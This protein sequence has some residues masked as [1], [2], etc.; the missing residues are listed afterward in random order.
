MENSTSIRPRTFTQP[1]VM[2]IALST[3]A[4]V[5][6]FILYSFIV[7]PVNFASSHDVVS[8]TINLALAV[9]VTLFASIIGIGYGIYR[10]SLLAVN[11]VHALSINNHERLGTFLIIANILSRKKFRRIFYLTSISYAIFF[12]MV[13]Q[14][15]IFR[16]DISF[17]QLYAVSIPSVN[18][19]TCCNFP[20]FVP[21]LSVYL[22]DNLIIVII[23]INLLV[24]VLLSVLVGINITLT[25]CMFQ[26]RRRTPKGNRLSCFTGIGGAT[27]GLF[28]AC[29]ICA[30]TLF[31][32]LLGLVTGMSSASAVTLSVLTP[33]QA[34]FI[35]VSIPTLLY[36]SYVTMKNIRKEMILGM[37]HG[38]NHQ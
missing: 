11:K 25:V 35:I 27:T 8:S 3:F 7:S 13:S 30:G 4:L 21:M 29:P 18:I 6:V 38:E 16:P 9:F 12:S 24:V 1:G 23:P 10:M 37:S 34:L 19:T 33:F 36:S 17:A 15:I 26:E 32:T 14:I 22:L 20:G 28:T 5:S 2:I 31:S